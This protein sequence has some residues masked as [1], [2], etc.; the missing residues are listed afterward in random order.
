MVANLKHSIKLFWGTSVTNTP[1]VTCC[2][3]IL[4]VGYEQNNP[5]QSRCLQVQDVFYMLRS[6][7][8]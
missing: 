4:L 8:Q 6:A 2:G 1:A 7:S 3:V 5:V